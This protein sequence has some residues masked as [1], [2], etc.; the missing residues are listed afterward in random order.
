VE[1]RIEGDRCRFFYGGKLVETERG[2]KIEWSF[3]AAEEM[4]GWRY[5]GLN[6]E[7]ELVCIVLW[8]IRTALGLQQ[9]SPL[10]T[11][12]PFVAIVKPCSKSPL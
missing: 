5:G 8:E 7:E 4:R 2:G 11:K 6:G 12:A 10:Q 9:T 1:W 3:S